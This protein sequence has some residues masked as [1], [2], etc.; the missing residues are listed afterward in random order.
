MSQIKSGKTPRACD[1]RLY[2]ITTRDKNIKKLSGEKERS[3]NKQTIDKL[4]YWGRFQAKW[5]SLADNLTIT[6]LFK[7]DT[8]YYIWT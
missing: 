7:S 3:L 2:L 4:Y 6:H 8:I 1:S 5:S